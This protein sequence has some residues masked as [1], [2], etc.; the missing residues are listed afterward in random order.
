MASAR[1]STTIVYS[2]ADSDSY[3]NS[4]LPENIIMAL[5]ITGLRAADFTNAMRTQTTTQ[6]QYGYHDRPAPSGEFRARGEG[7]GF[8]L[9]TPEREILYTATTQII[10]SGIDVSWRQDSLGTY[11]TTNRTMRELGMAVLD[12]EK[13]FEI[14]VVA[15]N[16]G[17]RISSID[18]NKG[19]GLSATLQ[20]LIYSNY[21]GTSGTTGWTKGGRASPTNDKVGLPVKRGIGADSDR[22]VLNAHEIVDICNERWQNFDQS[23]PSQNVMLS[24]NLKKALASSSN[25]AQG[26]FERRNN[27]K[28]S[29]GGTINWNVD[30]LVTETGMMLHIGA[31]KYMGLAKTVEATD[32]TTGVYTPGIQADDLIYLVEPSK[33]SKLIL[34]SMRT[35]ELPTAKSSDKQYFYNDVG[36]YAPE[37][38]H[39]AMV[40]ARKAA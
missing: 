38:K 20:A 6:Q 7:Q 11:D 26:I 24:I 17:G 18:G 29:A 39:T 30:T 4:I 8:D 23:S 35:G 19:V 9:R 36:V 37:E 14:F 2:Q 16:S 40:A 22:V 33:V 25:I 28:S 15:A 1:D 32:S 34:T 12:L 5:E 27:Q 13:G 3:K 21:E 31:N 10:T